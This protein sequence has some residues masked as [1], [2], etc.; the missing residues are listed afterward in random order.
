[1]IDNTSDGRLDTI[2]RWLKEKKWTQSFPGA[3]LV[4]F[5]SKKG[6]QFQYNTLF[7]TIVQMDDTGKV[8]D[9]ASFM[10][11]P[12]MG[13]TDWILAHDKERI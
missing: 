1:M 11:G 9:G 5:R 6:N 8:L 7:N 3:Y 10:Y 4:Q 12:Y 13:V 2:V